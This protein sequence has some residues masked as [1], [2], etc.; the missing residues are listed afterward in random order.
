MDRVEERIRDAERA[1]AA[2]REVLQVHRPDPMQRDSIILRFALAAESAWK[3]AQKLLQ[4]REALEFASPR[5]CV[6]GCL[7]AG[8]LGAE[9]ADRAMELLE[10]RNL[11]VHVYKE[12]LATELLERIP[13]HAG[14]L[15]RWVRGLR[16]RLAQ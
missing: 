2:L 5:A 10:D 1:V 9:D 7:Q 13:R 8:I 6:R 16:A 15:E 3:G 11:V 14:V 4:E 12:P